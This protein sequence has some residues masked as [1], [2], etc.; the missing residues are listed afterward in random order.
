MINQFQKAI[1]GISRRAIKSLG[2]TVA[3][4]GAVSD[5]ARLVDLFKRFDIDLVLDVGANVGQYAKMIRAWGYGG[6]IVSFEPQS[7]AHETLVR[8][9]R[10]DARWAI[11]PRCAIGGKDG[12]ID[13]NIS[14]NSVSSSVREMLPDHSK[15]SPSSKYVDRETVDLCKLESVARE[16]LERKRSVFLKIDTQGYED[17]VLKGAKGIFAQIRVVQ[18]ELSLVPLYRGQALFCEMVQKMERY[19]YELYQ[20]MPGFTDPETG[21]LLQVDGIFVRGE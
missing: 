5:G 1:Y 8:E 2:Y 14:E 18:L 10:G 12:T 3:R 13:L 6:D 7:A 21:R 11:A 15:A 9:S 19:G 16:F 20:M 4:V 17:E